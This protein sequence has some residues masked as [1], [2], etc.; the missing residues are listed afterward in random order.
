MII[1]VL[2]EIKQGETRVA[3]LP[4]GVK[5][6]VKAGH[7]VNVEF[8]AGSEI[9]VMD[10]DYEDAGFASRGESGFGQGFT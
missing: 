3:L 1:G 6:L 7:S 8:D 4:E 9:G 10:R 2:K 5:A